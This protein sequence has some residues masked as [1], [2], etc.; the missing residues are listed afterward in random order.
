MCG[1]VRETYLVEVVEV[2]GGDVV[3]AA[4]HVAAPAPARVVPGDERVDV[5]TAFL[6]PNNTL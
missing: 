1:W 3:Q 6:A 5:G 2:G 4:A